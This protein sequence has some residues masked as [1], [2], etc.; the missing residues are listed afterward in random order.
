M[1][2]FKLDNQPKINPGFKIPEGY[3][4]SLP[5][6]ILTKTTPEPIVIPLYRKSIFKLAAAVVL[7][8]VLIPI[9][10]KTFQS[11]TQFEINNESIEN[12]LSYTTDLNAFDL[13]GLIDEEDLKNFE[14]E[15]KFESNELE[16]L[17][18]QNNNI[19]LYLID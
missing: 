13:I 15:Y 11:N 9:G 6:K 5:E 2:N 14:M 1:S 4:E 8:A 12:Y 18:L 17:L 19:D 3:F 10:L 16:T 7:L